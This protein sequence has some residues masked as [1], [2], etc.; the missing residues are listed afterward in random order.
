MTGH[1]ILVSGAKK[2]L[3]N[4]I[5]AKHSM[6]WPSR[7]LVASH[8]QQIDIVFIGLQLD[9]MDCMALVA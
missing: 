7:K 3:T 8:L 4:C 5:N 2:R 9:P 6:V 1:V